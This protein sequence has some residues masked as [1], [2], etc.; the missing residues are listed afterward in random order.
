MIAVIAS[1]TFAA[2]GQTPSVPTPNLIKRTTTKTD[3]FDFGSG[4]TIIVTG[5]PSGS[6]K[7]IGSAKNEVEI[8]AEIEVQAA[9]ES[10]LTEL[11]KITGFVTD[12]S[13]IR[14]SVITV[15]VHNKFGLKKLP[16]NF[17]KHLMGL[18][19][20]INYTI[21]V[22]RYSDLEING[23]KGDLSIKG[24]EGSM[25]VNFIDSKATVEV[26][27]GNTALTIG[28][29]SLDLAFG[30]RGWRGR[31][32]DIQVASGDLNVWLPSNMSAEIDAT[33]LKEG[34]IENLIPDLK[35]R[36]RKVP[37]TERSIAA[38]A[39]VGGSPLKFVVGAG[40]MKI[41][42]LTNSM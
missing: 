7:V 29:G 42:R 38:K 10:D 17:P 27:A 1:F 12:E 20:T 6:V 18:P 35:P 37:F 2:F 41:E 9:S 13:A 31:Y 34:V 11:S 32:A 36:D 14:T 25:R 15:G 28:T 40:K 22:P 21:T 3:R 8:V 16:K 39:G 33:I 23:G 24:V 4:G 30:V 5:A 19:F 26:I